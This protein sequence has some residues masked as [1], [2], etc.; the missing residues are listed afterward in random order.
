VKGG[1]FVVSRIAIVAGEEALLVHE[2][3]TAQLEVRVEVVLGGCEAALD[4]AETRRSRGSG[5]GRGHA[6]PLA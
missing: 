6:P 3:R 4:R 5:A 1:A 2:H